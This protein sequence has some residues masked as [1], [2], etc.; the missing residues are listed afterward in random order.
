MLTTLRKIDIVPLQVRIDATIAE[1]D[2]NNA[3]EYGTQFF[4]KS[5]GGTTTA[6]AGSAA[7]TTSA[8]TIGTTA[9]TASSTLA[10][11]FT[12]TTSALT[13]GGFQ[14][15]LLSGG[16]SQQAALDLLQTVSKV[17]VLSSPEL[18]VLDN[19]AAR[20]QVGQ[21]VPV[22]S[23]QQQSTL[24]ANSSLVNSVSYVQTGVLL[25]ITPRVNTDGQVTLDVAE[26]VSSSL[27]ITTTGG[28]AGPASPTF[29]DR[30][31]QSRVVVQD[32][33]TIGIAGLIQDQD[34]RQNQGVP[35]LR[36]VPV[37]GALFGQQA[38]QRLRTELLVM[39]TP[40][41]E[42]DARDARAVTEDMEEQVPFAAGVPAGLQRLPQEGLSD[43]QHGVLRGLGLAH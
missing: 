31:V 4:F 39:I 38:N 29:S 14:G 30:N 8:A 26:E 25:Q 16:N 32:G 11:V 37:I 43:P 36:N 28:G 7:S 5:A 19:Q 24:V 33:Q 13:G 23:E 20:L 40:H 9:A 2:L 12:A 6:G 21:D 27:G 1:V 22:L 3:L 34:Q 41:V 42:H 35:F 15:F 10:P 17:R 18:V